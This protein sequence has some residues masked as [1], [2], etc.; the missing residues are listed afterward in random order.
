MKA[1]RP[2]L[3]LL[4]PLALVLAAACSA[5]P[6]GDDDPS[7]LAQA[8]DDKADPDDGKACY[9]DVPMRKGVMSYGVCCFDD[10]QKGTSECIIC[11]AAHTCTKG[12]AT[13]GALTAQGGLIVNTGTVL[14]VNDA[15]TWTPPTKLT[16]TTASAKNTLTKQP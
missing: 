2:E 12:G 3:G 9:Q 1:S 13:P 10:P 8:L 16:A 6:N 11:D 15:G 4:L 14:G 5:A 7:N